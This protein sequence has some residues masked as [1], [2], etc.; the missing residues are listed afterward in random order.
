MKPESYHNKYMGKVRISSV[1]RLSW[2]PLAFYSTQVA[3]VV[4]VPS[5]VGADRR[6]LLAQLPPAARYR[7]PK[8]VVGYH[9]VPCLAFGFITHVLNAVLWIVLAFTGNRKW[10][11]IK[12][13]S[14][15]IEREVR[16]RVPFC[17]P[18]SDVAL[19]RIDSCD[20]FHLLAR[21]R[22]DLNV[23]CAIERRMTTDDARLTFTCAVGSLDGP[24]NAFGC[25]RGAE[26]FRW[27]SRTSSTPVGTIG[28]LR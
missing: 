16:N 23:V 27:L 1:L 4:A 13:I 25:H 11:R 15:S 17:P 26:R 6:N 20:T 28:Y 9:N 5:R 21:G 3:D 7:C 2:Y 19:G 10:H 18:E 24:P 12:I 22:K 14:I 8:L